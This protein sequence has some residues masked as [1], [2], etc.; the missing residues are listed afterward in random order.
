MLGET[1][2]VVRSERDLRHRL[3]WPH[4]DDTMCDRTR[5]LGGEADRLFESGGL[6]ER[7]TGDWKV[8]AQKRPPLVS[9]PAPS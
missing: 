5:G 6:D 7:E 1:L 8:R 2:P 3:Q 4:L 9:T